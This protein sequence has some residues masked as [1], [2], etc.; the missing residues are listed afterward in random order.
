[1]AEIEADAPARPVG[2]PFQPGNPGRP[3]GSRNALGEAFLAALHADFQEHG[4]GAIAATRREKP[5][6]YVKVVAKLLPQRVQIE[7][8]MRELSDDE[9]QDLILGGDGAEHG[10]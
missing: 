5:A 9:L 7:R 2:R 4:A 10:A 3:K 1:M 8:T 6:E